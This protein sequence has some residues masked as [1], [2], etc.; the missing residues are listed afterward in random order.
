MKNYIKYI[1][2]VLAAAFASVGCAHFDDM[3][4][5]PYVVY[6]TNSE[7]FVQPMIYGAQK[8]IAYCEYYLMGELMQWTVNTNYESSAQLTYNY[9]LSENNCRM[10]WSLYNQFGNAQYMLD[11]AR[12]ECENGGGNPAMIGVALTLRS[13]IGHILTDTYGNVPYSKAGQ[14]ALQGDTF[15]YTTPYDEQKDIYVDLLRSMEEANQCFAKAKEMKDSGALSSLDFNPICDFMYDGNIEKWHRF[16]NSLYLRLLMRA[17]NKALE[18]SEGIIA[19]G[20]EFGDLN[21]IAKINEIYDSY[22]SGAGDYPVMR[23][24]DDSAR[25]QFSSKDSALYT[26]FYSTTSGN[27]NGQAACKTLVDWMLITD[28]NGK[29]LYNSAD[30]QNPDKPWDPRYFRYFT[31]AL[32][33]PSQVTREEM[34]EYFESNVSSAGNSLIGRY[35]K[36]GYTG[37]HIG[38]L[39]M[40][41]KYSLLNYDEIIFIFAE[42]GARGWIPMSQKAYKDLYLEANRQ[43]ILLWQDGWE[44]ATD[45]YTAQS[46]EVINFINYLDNEFD[47]NK[48][49]ETIMRQKYVAT[50]WVGVEGWADYR[51]TG[52]PILKTNGDAAQNKQILPTRLRYPSTEAFQNAKH[53]TEVVN[54]WL[55]GENN[56]VTDMWFANTT[57][58]QAIRRLGRK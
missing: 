32:G 17:S 20:E 39:K 37:T 18:E 26:S 13:W 2:I 27:W 57:E 48:A 7:S 9:V 15:E 51:R 58:S 22:L 43:S 47:Y 28:V 3:N 38:D 19:L 29:A 53:Y 24:I 25:L 11:L 56:M 16:A 52:Y 44:K 31:K 40:D 54:G 33:A 8:Q 36:G 34:R 4:K 49:V 30:E 23:N 10:M 12:K 50:F 55:G 45:Y 41:P 6:E 21:V 14:I 42:A 35:P 46:P 1:T 5:N